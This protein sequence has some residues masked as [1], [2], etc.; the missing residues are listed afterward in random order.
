MSE[1]SRMRA[2]SNME[3]EEQLKKAIT[4]KSDLSLVVYNDGI[5]K[6]TMERFQ[7]GLIRFWVEF[8]YKNGQFNRTLVSLYRH[9]GMLHHSESFDLKRAVLDKLISIYTYLER[10]GYIGF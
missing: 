9:E 6:I 3:I 10:F 2:P 1:R 5:W 7:N 4:S 8:E